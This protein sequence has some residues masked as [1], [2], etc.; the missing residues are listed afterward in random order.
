[1]KVSVIAALFAVSQAVLLENKDY[2][3]NIPDLTDL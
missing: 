3:D 2:E 1:M